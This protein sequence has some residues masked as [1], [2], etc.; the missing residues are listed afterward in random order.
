[1]TPES[2]SE[3][4]ALRTKGL[5][6]KQIARKLG[7]K[8]SQVNS[9]IKQNAEQIAIAKGKSGELAPIAECL[10]NAGCAGRLLN[11]QELDEQGIG[12]LG[13]VL[14]ARKTGYKR[15]VICSYLIDYW[16]LGLKDTIGERK[17]D[18]VQ[19]RQFIEMAFQGFPEGYQEITLEQAQA[20]VYGA[21]DYAAGL[22]LK[23][24]KDFQ[25]TEK[26]LG[27]WNNQLKL[28]FG[29]EGK[30]YFMSGPYDN[31]NQIM[32]TLTKNVGEGNFHYTIG[33]E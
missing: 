30:P 25:K 14:V 6:S 11:N 12:G 8:A 22:G 3:I 29:R 18:D 27:T 1:M 20:I 21:I 32:Q 2:E 10:V 13:M 17:M 16:C 24:H 15:F 33:L 7:L 9:V 31:T 5:T 28:T 4:L 19:Y 26:H 23:P